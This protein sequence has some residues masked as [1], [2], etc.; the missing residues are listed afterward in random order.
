MAA[1]GATDNRS[2]GSSGSSRNSHKS[3]SSSRRS[4]T[5]AATSNADGARRIDDNPG[6][7]PRSGAV[8]HPDFADF[9]VNL[10]STTF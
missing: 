7:L 10:E 3:S 5:A 1:A 8:A 2:S 6:E 4:S 9:V